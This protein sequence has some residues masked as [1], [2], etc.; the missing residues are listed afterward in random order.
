MPR[1]SEHNTPKLSIILSK[2]TL[3]MAY[4]AFILANTAAT[5][6]Y[7]VNVFFTFWGMNVIS[8]KTVNDL[9]VDPLG[10]PALAMPNVVG[11]IPGMTDF[12]TKMMKKKIKKIKIP[13][14]YEMIKQSK[15]IGV[16]IYACTT[17]M[18]LMDLKKEDFVPEVEDMVGAATFLEMSEGGQIIFI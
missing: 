2:G 12:L 5:M 17:T 15:D 7:S 6:G 14:I 1:K 18:S 16:K 10:N 9:K 3:D 11:V 4:P 8:K 13:T